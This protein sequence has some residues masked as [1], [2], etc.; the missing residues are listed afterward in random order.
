MKQAEKAERYA[1]RSLKTAHRDV[2]PSNLLLDARGTVWV[3]DF[4]LAKADDHLDLTVTGDILGTLRYMSPEALEGKADA[5]GDI[6]SLG[7]TLY[8]LVA[9]R[10]AFGMRDRNLLIKQVSSDE[11]RQLGRSARAS[12][13][14]SRRSCTR[15]SRRTRPFAIRPPGSWRRTFRDSWTTSRSG[16]VG[17]VPRSGLRLGRGTTRAWPAWCGGLRAAGGA[18]GG[19]DDRGLADRPGKGDR[20]ACGDSRS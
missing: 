7:L 17:R 2:K 9:L 1:P 20:G 11:A 8:E 5:R 19:S 3:T 6:Y 14:T 15:R 18:G 16:P 12:R 4:G 13:G 10:P